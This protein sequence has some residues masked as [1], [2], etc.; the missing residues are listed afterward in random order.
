ML[1]PFRGT[2]SLSD[3]I[4]LRPGGDFVYQAFSSDLRD[5]FYL[6]LARPSLKPQKLKL[7]LRASSMDILVRLDVNGSPHKN[8]DGHRL[9][10]T[11]L[12]LYREGAGD[13]WAFLLDAGAFSNPND[14]LRAFFDFC[15]Y[16]RIDVTS[17]MGWVRV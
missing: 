14:P 1:E 8:P 2:S 10:G 16:C 5:S 4:D 3:A 17:L 9:G 7:Q 6:D 15:G 13:D 12:H 11:H